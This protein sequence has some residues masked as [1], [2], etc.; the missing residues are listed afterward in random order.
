MKKE[1]L[2]RLNKK[3]KDYFHVDWHGRKET[4]E[5]WRGYLPV[6]KA[7]MDG[8]ALE[9]VKN[10]NEVELWYSNGGLDRTIIRKKNYDTWTDQDVNDINHMRNGEWGGLKELNDVICNYISYRKTCAMPAA[11]RFWLENINK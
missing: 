5:S 11:F 2:Y 4:M 7:I 8:S 1:K 3:A 6:I 10:D 9:E